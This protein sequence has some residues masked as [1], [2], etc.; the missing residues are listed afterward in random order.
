MLP[1]LG[2]AIYAVVT[3]DDPEG[4]ESLMTIVTALGPMQAVTGSQLVLGH[5][6]KAAQVTN[7]RFKVY[8]YS[9]REDVTDQ[10]KPL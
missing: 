8:K 4:H 1:P 3:N 9:M 10:F 6:I 7:R 5:F 2:D